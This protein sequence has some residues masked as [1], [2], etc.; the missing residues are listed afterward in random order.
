MKANLALADIEYR[1][2][3]LPDD[4]WVRIDYQ[5]E[6]KWHSM[7]AQCEVRDRPFYIPERKSLTP[8]AKY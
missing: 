2:G 3:R 1:N 6:L 5:R 8:P 4:L 7:W